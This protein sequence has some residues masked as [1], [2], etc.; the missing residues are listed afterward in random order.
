MEPYKRF[1][2][3]VR[4]FLS[5]QSTMSSFAVL[6]FNYDVALNVALHLNGVRFDYCLEEVSGGNALAYLKLHGSLNWGQC[7]ECKRIIPYEIK[8]VKLSL[9]PRSKHVLYNLGST[10]NQKQHHAKPLAGPPIIVPPTWNKATHHPQL[11][12]VWRRAC[13]EFER[14]ENIFIAGYSLPETDSFFRYLFALGTQ[15]RT[16][17]KRLWVV[18]P[19]P[20]GV[21][22]Q[23]VEGFV[24]QA[25]RSRLKCLNISFNDFTLMRDFR[26]AIN[27]P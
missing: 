12:A 20:N 24:G 27:E 3:Q 10:L 13:K 19:D 23:R 14:A 7:Q 18:D 4:E 8:D 17:I 22:G 16:Q 2:D 1:T 26:E 6:T 15:G 21:V 9:R 25:I 5:N 11:E